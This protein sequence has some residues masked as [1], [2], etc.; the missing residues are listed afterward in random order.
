MLDLLVT[1]PCLTS[2]GDIVV[3]RGLEESSTQDHHGPARS[4]G[5]GLRMVGQPFQPVPARPGGSRSRGRWSSGPVQ[6]AELE[7]SARCRG[8]HSAGFSSVPGAPATST[9]TGR[10]GTTDRPASN[11]SAPPR[12]C[13]VRLEAGSADAAGCRC[14]QRAGARPPTR[15]EVQGSA[16]VGV[17]AS[18][19]TGPRPQRR[20]V[21]VAPMPHSNMLLACGFAGF[22][23]HRVQVAQVVRRPAFQ[24]GCPPARGGPVCRAPRTPS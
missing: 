23:R 16:R 7:T 6:P 10:L 19:A 22:H 14:G 2:T 12:S 1:G 18:P 15:A 24:L 21:G 11:H 13:L 3:R 4:A 8:P 5:A 17:P 20:R 9:I